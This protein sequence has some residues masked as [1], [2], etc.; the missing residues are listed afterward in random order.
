MF[1]HIIKNPIL[2]RTSQNTWKHH[3][4]RLAETYTKMAALLSKLHNL[5]KHG[6]GPSYTWIKCIK[7]SS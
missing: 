2:V 4:T 6:L 7:A 3:I 5:N 1:P